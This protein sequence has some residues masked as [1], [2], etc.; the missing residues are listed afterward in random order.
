MTSN[1]QAIDSRRKAAP[2][3]RARTDGV[4]LVLVLVPRRSRRSG[5]GTGPGPGPGPGRSGLVAARVVY[6]GQ[7]GPPVHRL[8]GALA[9]VTLLAPS[10]LAAAV[11]AAT[12]T[13]AATSAATT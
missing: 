12:A 8:A 7:P 13:T 3:Y 1:R 11:R 9:A 2:G 5:A 4:Y 10:T 6:A